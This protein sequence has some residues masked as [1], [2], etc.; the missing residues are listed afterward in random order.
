MK[1]TRLNFDDIKLSRNPLMYL[2]RSDSESTSKFALET[3]PKFQKINAELQNISS[4]LENFAKD[5]NIKIKFK[6]DPS[7]NNEADHQ[8]NITVTDNGFLR[9][10]LSE[11]RSISADTEAVTVFQPEKEYKY[12]ENFARRVFRTVGELT[13]QL[14]NQYLK[15]LKDYLEFVRDYQLNNLY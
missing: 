12:E 1:I 10:Y 9:K 2:E 11:N 6:F 8:L 15:N 4:T 3:L 14:R 7:S 5:E 13:V